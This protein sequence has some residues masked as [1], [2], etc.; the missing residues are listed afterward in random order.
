M[1]RQCTRAV[2][3]AAELSNSGELMDTILKIK[4]VSPLIGKAI[5]LPSYATDGSAGMDLR[6]CTTQAITLL[7][8]ERVAVDTG[9][10]IELPDNGYFAM[11]CARSGLS[12]KHGIA[13]ANGVGVVDSDYRGEIRVSLVNL[14]SCAYTIE[15]GE[16]IAQMLIMP[17][18]HAKLQLCDELDVTQR[19]SG[20]FGS[21]GRG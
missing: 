9:I 7:P 12:T 20:G 11:I 16:R 15:P 4:A 3:T 13:L 6:A 14:S 10:A 5:E 18:C 17:V 2:S 19:G 8:G 21:T 1:C